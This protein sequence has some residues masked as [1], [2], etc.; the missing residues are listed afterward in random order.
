M[1]YADDP[2]RLARLLRN[3]ADALE[4]AGVNPSG[5]SDARHLM[6]DARAAAREL[7]GP[8]GPRKPGRFAAF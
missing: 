5:S 6:D 7:Q 2:Q 4:E 3:L 8:D 1:T